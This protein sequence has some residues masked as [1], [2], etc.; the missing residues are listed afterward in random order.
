MMQIETIILNTSLIQITEKSIPENFLKSNINATS[1][2]E[3]SFTGNDNAKAKI[4]FNSTP[5]TDAFQLNKAGKFPSYFNNIDL[6][7]P[8][9]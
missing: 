7:K 3:N 4:N 1:C 6:L 8:K 2:N 9:K 5:I